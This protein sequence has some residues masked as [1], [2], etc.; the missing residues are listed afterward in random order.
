MNCLPSNIIT[1]IAI[2][3]YQIFGAGYEIYTDTVE[4]DW[5]EPCFLILCL[6]QTKEPLSQFRFKRQNKYNIQYFPKSSQAKEIS[7]VTDQLFDGMCFIQTDSGLVRGTKMQAEVTDGILHFQ[8]Q[9]DYICVEE[10]P[11]NEPMKKIE[12]E[13]S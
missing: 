2:R 1:A 3:L 9:Y 4:Q 6:S 11:Q 7:N 8:V 12:V 13:H 10:L 5:T